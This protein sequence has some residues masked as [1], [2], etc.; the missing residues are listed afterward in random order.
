M[1]ENE[2]MSLVTALQNDSHGE[3]ARLEAYNQGEHIYG[4]RIDNR[5]DGAVKV[6]VHVQWPR[7]HCWIV[8]AQR[9]GKQLVWDHSAL[10]SETVHVYVGVAG[11]IITYVAV[12]ERPE[13]LDMLKEHGQQAS[14]E[15]AAEDM[16]NLVFKYEC[17]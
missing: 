9:E 12:L 6:T 11:S 15:M 2:I 4:V 14:P 16:W 10:G 1:F 3:A 13:L 8:N 17:L 7:L 5:L